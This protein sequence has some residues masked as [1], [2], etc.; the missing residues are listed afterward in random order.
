MAGTE[1][2]INVKQAVSLK[3][4][5]A[6]TIT[7]PQNPGLAENNW[8]GPHQDSYC[9]E[10]VYLSGPTS[11]NLRTIAMPNPYGFIVI[12]ACN[13]HNQMVA[14]AYSDGVL[15]II[16]YDTDC[17]ILSAN[18]TGKAFEDLTSGSFAGGYF[19]L[20]SDEHSIVVGDNKL[21]AFPTGLV[22]K[23]EEVIELELLW[24]SD[25]IVKAITEEDNVLYSTMP[26]WST[27]PGLYWCLLGGKYS[28]TDGNDV[29]ITSSAYIAVVQITRAPRQT[30]G[31]AKST[32]DVITT[33]LAKKELNTPFAQYNNNTFAVTE[34]GAVFVTN[35]LDKSNQCTSGYCYRV[36]YASGAGITVTWQKPYSNSGYLKSGQKNV[37]SGT[38]P[39]IMVDDSGKMLVAIT[40]NAYPQMNVV[41]FDYATGDKVS[42]TPVFSKM[43]SANEASVIGVK[44]TI[45]VPNN[46]GHTLTTVGSQ[47]VS[48]E[49]G[50]AK[51][52][53]DTGTNSTSADIIWN[54]DH[55]TFFGMSM[56]ARKSGIIF[57]YSGEWYD[58]ASALEGP[59][60]YVLAIDSFD[61]RVIW[62]IPFG[63][64]SPYAHAY[65][66]IYFDRTGQKIFVGASNFIISVQ[67]YIETE[68]EEK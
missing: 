49:P 6:D 48:N 16:V 21:K 20:D 66:G 4:E 58:E 24:E 62:R 29:I 38:T 3:N 10:S 17:K 53:V 39:T 7:L 37:G 18:Y 27:D 44:N 47:Y 1:N 19:Y 25:D 54:Q 43:R 30:R 63:R 61:G 23:Q 32:T 52:A 40:D 15:R 11:S 46:F 26:V 57:A 22:S 12:Q 14:M 42:E 59:V 8:S 31:G 33:V 9:S 28:V 60:Y 51:I 45:F 67:D 56:L 50:L 55:Y 68:P 41:V 65:G 64:G 5:F 35:G 34:D 2:I 36:S 13:K